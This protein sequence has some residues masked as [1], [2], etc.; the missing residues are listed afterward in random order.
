MI[1]FNTN[2]IQLI[3]MTDQEYR[4]RKMGYESALDDED[5]D[6]FVRFGIAWSELREKDWSNDWYFRD[7]WGKRF[8]NHEEYCF[9]TGD[10]MQALVSVDGIENAIERLTN[11]LDRY[12]GVH[13]S[14]VKEARERI[15]KNV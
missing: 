6:R 7:N 12:N 3:S 15:V 11:T 2:K 5:V 14:H 9:A 8:R 10:A 13:L 4:F 1:M